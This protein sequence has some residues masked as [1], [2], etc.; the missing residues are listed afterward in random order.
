VEESATFIESLR[1]GGREFYSLP[2]GHGEPGE[3]L[4][5]AAR[6]E[7][8]EEAGLEGLILLG[9]LGVRER[10][11]F[12][13]TS[14]KTTHYYLFLAAAATPGAQTRS[15]AD[16][17][18]LRTSEY[19]PEWFALDALPAMFWPEQ[20]ELL[21]TERERIRAA[22]T[23]HQVQ[24]QFNRQAASYARSESHARDRDLGLLVDH[25][26]LRPT[27]RA[28]D[29]AT[30]TGFTAFALARVAG[31]VVGLDLTL[32]M[33]REARRLSPVPGIRW[34]AADAGALPFGDA[35]F[36]VVTVR[37]APHHFPDLERALREMLRLLNGGGRIG[38]V[39]QVPPDDEP[40]R[41]L[42]ERLEKLRDAS[43]VEAYTSGRWRRLLER[44]GVHIAFAGLVER[45]VSFEAWLELAG[46]DPARRTAIEEALAQ[47]SRAAR[48][49]I[50]DDGREP[51]SFMKRWVVLVGTKG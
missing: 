27:D 4:E 37:R 1:E 22:V 21:L 11:D 28:L 5:D 36:D 39:D 50:G 48:A 2:K 14:W 9:P 34:V 26:H 35:T 10:L 40:G 8:E 44:L 47:A 20:R 7:L 43:H 24:Q 19:A 32:G 31:S 17:A 38:V 29:V 30:G 16:A 25:L 51:R 15:P 6:R 3:R 45:P 46:A 42:M 18:G 41:V 13:R 23:R 49:E 12:E 33:L